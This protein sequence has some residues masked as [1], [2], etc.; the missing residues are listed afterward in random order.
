[1]PHFIRALL[2]VVA[3]PVGLVVGLVVLGV[4]FDFTDAYSRRYR[5]WSE[6][7]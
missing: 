1:M 6:R 4:V 5:A 2:I 3:L 7:E